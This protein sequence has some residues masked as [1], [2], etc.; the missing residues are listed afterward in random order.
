M[1][2]SHRGAKNAPRT[3]QKRTKIA[4]GR[5]EDARGNS[6]DY[7][8]GSLLD[9]MGAPKVDFGSHFGT[10]IDPKIYQKVETE[11]DAEKVSKM[12]PK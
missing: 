1:F 3:H 6:K 11:I 9:K 12:M 10:K 8:F 7:A 4:Q 2:F 5:P